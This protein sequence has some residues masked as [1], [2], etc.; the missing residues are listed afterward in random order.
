MTM[1]HP[2]PNAAASA[3]SEAIGPGQ[4]RLAFVIP[5]SHGRARLELP[6]HAVGQRAGTHTAGT[7]TATAALTLAHAEPLVHALEQWLDEAL[8]PL[9]AWVEEAHHSDGTGDEGASV[10]GSLQRGQLAPEGSRVTVPAAWL[11]AAALPTELAQAFNWDSVPSRIIMDHLRTACTADALEVGDLLLLPGSYRAPWAALATPVGGTELPPVPLDL[12]ASA[13][14]RPG[15]TRLAPDAPRLPDPQAWSVEVLLPVHLPLGALLPEVQLMA[16]SLPRIALADLDIG[17][18][19]AQGELLGVGRL[20]PVALGWG[21]RLEEVCSG[22]A[23]NATA[24]LAPSL[25]P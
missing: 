25:A 23:C 2:L 15:R 14:L 5:S 16:D 12:D 10:S 6:S 1:P 24:A 21:L 11:Q 3:P 9:P 8:D 19:D 20:L 7:R 4:D 22:S 17:V 18:F 13:S